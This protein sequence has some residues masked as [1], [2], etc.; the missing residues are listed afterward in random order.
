MLRVAGSESAQDEMHGRSLLDEIAREAAS[1]QNS[2]PWTRLRWIKPSWLDPFFAFRNS[3]AH[4]RTRSGEKQPS[5]RK[6]DEFGQRR[7]V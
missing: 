3:R 5:G 4:T 1:I 6:C 7:G 2:R